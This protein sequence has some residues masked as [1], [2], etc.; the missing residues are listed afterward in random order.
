LQLIQSFGKLASYT[1]QNRQFEQQRDFIIIKI[2]A[3][4]SVWLVRVVLCALLK[5]GAPIWKEKLNWKILNF[6]E[7]LDLTGLK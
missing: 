2:S 7:V 4:I 1:T 6:F 3:L 5:K